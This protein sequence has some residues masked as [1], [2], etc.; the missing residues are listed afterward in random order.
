M[1]HRVILLGLL[2]STMGLANAQTARQIY[3]VKGNKVVATVP[4]TDVDYISFSTPSEVLL[5]ITVKQGD[6]TTLTMYNSSDDWDKAPEERKFDNYPGKLVKFMW[7]PDYGFSGALKITSASGAN[8]PFDYTTDDEEFGTCWF[9]VMPEEPITIETIGTEM[10]K[11]ASREFV[12]DYRGYPITVGEN[13]ITAL[14]SPTFSLQL[15]GNTS[16]HATVSGEKT[17]AGCYI[18]D[19]DRNTF[20]YDENYS[21]DV[22]GKKTFGVSGTWFEGGDALVIVNNLTDDR[23]DNNRYYFVS[24]SD[25]SYIMASSDV[26]A[27][28]NL[29]EK[30]G[31]GTTSWYYYNKIDGTI[32]PVDVAFAQGSSIDNAEDALVSD[33]EGNALFRYSHRS[34]DTFPVFTMKGKEAGTYTAESGTGN[35][36]VLDGFG[37]AT[38]GDV[39]GTYIIVNGVL[40][41]TSATDVETTFLLDTTNH[42]YSVAASEE[43]D[44][45]ESFA[46]AIIGNYDSNSSSMGMFAITLN[47]D[48]E[49]N[50]V[51]GTVKVQV[52]LTSDWYETKDIIAN[53]ASYTYDASAHQITISGLL[54]GTANGR[55]TERI[56]ITFDVNDDKTVLTCNE[57]KVLRAVSGGDTRYV[58][59]K[60]LTLNAK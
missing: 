30:R 48:F 12:G 59:L 20:T 41:L 44:G 28:R 34:P 52:S 50:E 27:S 55:G 21:A 32:E 7:Y 56:N 23:P 6:N 40:T 8:V 45:A 29:I 37:N 53:T 13:G 49:G 9:C 18:F 11:Y 60:G 31:N 38:Y 5:P 33:K 3:L 39:N 19:D 2:A 16:F 47:H 36:L 43:W 26:Y 54:V 17:F 57:D 15:S 4:A 35:Y 51:K 42:T 14:S 10:T 24:T 22:Y 46:N 25:F 1:K 58:N